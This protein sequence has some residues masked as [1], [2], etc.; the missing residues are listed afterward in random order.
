MPL[1]NKKIIQQ[2]LT[3]HAIP[4]EHL[5]ILQDWQ[6]LID[7]K[8]LAKHKE[9]AVVSAFISKLLETVLGYQSIGQGSHYSLAHEYSIANGQVDAALGQFNNDKQGDKIHAVFEFKGAKTKNLDTLISGKK[10]TPVEQAWRYA[11]DA[12]G[13]QW[14]LVSNYLEVRLYAFGE[15]SL[16]YEAFDLAKLTDPTEYARF[17]LCLH[18]HQLLTGKTYELLQQSQQADKDITAQLYDDYKG[19]REQLITRLIAD[20]P[21]IAPLDCVSPAQKLLD[22]IL[23]VAFAE[24]RGLLPHDSIE[25]AYQHVDI[26]NPQPIYTNFK[27]LFNAIN[28]GNA[29]LKVPAYNGGLFASDKL[30]DKLTA[31]RG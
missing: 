3:I 8:N 25:R 19:L 29:L 11:R 4:V 16:F 30:L 28:K 15:T 21:D 20:N 23:F 18:A 5:S 27:G 7:N 22:R 31:R 13:C 1:F 2:N 9:T 14:I 24:D 26:Y 17:I 12:K 10:E 6:T